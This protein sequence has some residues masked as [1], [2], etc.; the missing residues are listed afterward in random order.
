MEGYPAEVCINDRPEEGL[1][2]TVRLGTE[3]LMDCDGILYLVSDQ[4][5]LVPST[6][7]PDCVGVA[8]AA[9]ADCRRLSWRT[10]GESVLV[11]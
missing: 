7:G 5:L 9:G 4:P 10:A 3:Q 8:A 11:S 6:V 1:S 2:R